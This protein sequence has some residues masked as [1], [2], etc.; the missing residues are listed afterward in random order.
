MRE[1]VGKNCIVVIIIKREYRDKNEFIEEGFI[2]KCLLAEKAV[3]A[4]IQA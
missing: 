3:I 4:F 1:K 2:T